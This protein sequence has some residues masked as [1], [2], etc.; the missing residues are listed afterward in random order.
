MKSPSPKSDGS[1]KSRT[2]RTEKWRIAKPDKLNEATAPLKFS[3]CKPNG[4]H[5]FES[6][7]HKNAD[8]MA[9]DAT[10]RWR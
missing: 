6:I 5:K 2:L 4:Q 7:K 3:P 9:A 1:K 10:G 8:G